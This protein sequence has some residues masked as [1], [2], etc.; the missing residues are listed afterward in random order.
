MLVGLYGFNTY[1][2]I[3]RFSLKNYEY[4]A[5]EIPKNVDRTLVQEYYRAIEGVN[6]FVS[7]QWSQYKIDVRNPKKDNEETNAAVATYREKVAYIRFLESEINSTK[8]D[9]TA[10]EK[11]RLIQS[12]KEA[13]KN[14]FKQ[15][16]RELKIGDKG[17]IIFELQR[18][19]SKKGMPITVDGVFAEET[20]NALKDFEGKQ[21][22][23]VDGKLDF[24]TLEHLLR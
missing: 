14:I 18:A 13:V 12:D 8:E 6:G 15:S 10:K 21:G 17:V 20:F 16:K 19:L 4:K 3:E 22:L 1:K 5:A 24:L 9:L 2:K 23:Y 7:S 11:Q